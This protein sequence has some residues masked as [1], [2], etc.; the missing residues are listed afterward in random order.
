MRGRLDD[1]MAKQLRI[2]LAEIHE[3]ENELVVGREPLSGTRLEESEGFSPTELDDLNRWLIGHWGEAIVAGPH[4]PLFS[5]DPGEL[6]T[7]IV[8]DD[9]GEIE[10]GVF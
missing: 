2:A 8:P 6:V 4:P 5:S 1:D 9:Q 3:N 10:P 7:A